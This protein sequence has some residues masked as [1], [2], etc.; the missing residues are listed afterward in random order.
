MNHADGTEHMYVFTSSDENEK[1]EEMKTITVTSSDSGTWTV[2]DDGSEGNK[3][4]KVV[5]IKGADGSDK[6]IG[7]N[8]KRMGRKRQSGIN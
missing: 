3:T 7:K 1:G 6:E 2:K 5:I 4:E 8:C